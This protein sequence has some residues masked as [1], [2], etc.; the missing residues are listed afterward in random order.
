MIINSQNKDKAPKSFL[1]N[2]LEI[3]GILLLAFLIRTFIFGLYQ[4]PTGSMETTL[5]VGERFFANKMVY[6]FRKPKRGEIIAFNQPKEYANSNNGRSFL[7]KMKLSAMDLYDRYANLK[8]QN[9]TKR[10][11][12]LPGEHIQG[13]IEDGKAVIYIDGK[14]W[15]D[16]D[17]YVNKYPLILV[18]NKGDKSLGTS[19]HKSFDPKIKDWSKQEFYKIDQYDI[20]LSNDGKAQI[21]PP[22]DM[23]GYKKK[24]DE[25]D[26]ILGD[27]EYWCMGDNRMGSFDSRAFGPVPFKLMHGQIV[28]RIL[29]LD[30]NESW[31][32]LDI[33]KNPI[34]FFKK[35]RWS[36]TF[37]FVS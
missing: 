20:L 12:G 18:K 13:K 27:D 25:F 10:I 23:G 32:I 16:N 1:R 17:K 31:L 29:S 9:W 3:I 26:V 30:T 7:E 28:F 4:V 24:Y 36:R 8:V 34:Q 22:V 15:E 33:L 37:Q 2:I 6:W 14:K 11:V 19:V 5:L 35:I 21:L